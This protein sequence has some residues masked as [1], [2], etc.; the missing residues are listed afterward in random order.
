MFS[1]P[2]RKFFN[3]ISYIYGRGSLDNGYLDNLDNEFSNK[4][5]KI[6]KKKSNENVLL[7]IDWWWFKFHI[8]SLSF[9][10]PSKTVKL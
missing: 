10:S 1:V 3:K 8:I 7:L 9:N 5:K 2:W 4:Y 6:L